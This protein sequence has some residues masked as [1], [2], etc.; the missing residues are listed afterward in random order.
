MIITDIDYEY[1]DSVSSVDSNYSI[2]LNLKKGKYFLISDI[3][4]RY[5]FTI[6]NYHGYTI[7]TYSKEK[8]NLL[9]N[10]ENNLNLNINHKE[11]ITNAVINYS[12]KSL[13]PKRHELDLDIYEQN[14]KNR[15]KF[16]FLFILLIIHLV[17]LIRI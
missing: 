6:D 14:L 16:P 3:I 10:N 12:N 9:K 11:I 8:I 15:N 2:E 5:I 4:Y 17:I 7:N 13:A 1:I